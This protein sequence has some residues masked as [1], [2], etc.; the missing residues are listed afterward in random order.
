MGAWGPD[1]VAASDHGAG[2]NPLVE[3]L[4]RAGREDPG[5]VAILTEGGAVTF[6][7]LDAL[8]ARLAHALVL[9]YGVGRGDRVAVQ[10]PRRPEVLALNVA[11]ARLGAVY[12]PLNPAY[13]DREVRGLLDDAAPALLV[14]DGP[15][16]HPVAR[17][18]CDELLGTAAGRPGVFVDEATDSATP[19]A[20]LFTSG[21][22]GRPKGAVLTQGNLVFGC[23]TLNRA[24]GITSA[25][26]VAHVLPLFHVHGLFVA[27]YCS[28]SSGATL[29]LLAGFDV[30][31][32]LEAL[33]ASTVMMGVPTHYARLLADERL[34]AE[35]VHGVRL[36]VSGSAPLPPS[37]FDAFWTRTGHRIL[38]RYGTT[39]TG[40]I[41]SNP[42]EGERRPGSVGAALPGVEVRVT[43]TPGPVEVRGPN[44]FV[45]YWNRPELG[46][47]FTPDGFFDTGDLAVLDGEGRLEIVGRAKDVIITGGL[48]VYPKEVEQVLD[49]LPG[50]AESAVVGVA[51]DDLGEA[52]AAAVVSDPGAAL[53]GGELR[54]RARESLAPFKVPRHVVL[55]A[56]LPR[57]A[58]GKVEKARLRRDLGELLRRRAAE[59]GGG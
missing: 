42:L 32:V 17:A 30:G 39:E 21:T 40:M 45:G 50:V 26:V 53:D 24:W 10:L 49:G 41:A 22:T 33:G 59:P 46:D 2:Q 56:D 13:T 51:D 20:L 47:V 25:D 43:G 7:E 23:T 48:N 55:V 27:A 3:T 31:E 44:V 5:R 6:A 19:A 28:L 34:T 36:F 4:L 11:C 14:R 8:S 37:L 9:E 15:L 16:E 18:S 38:E 58:M 29:R 12:V 35:R 52:V 1:Q 57:N 54:V